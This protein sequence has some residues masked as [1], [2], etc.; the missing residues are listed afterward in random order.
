MTDTIRFQLRLTGDTAE[1][2]QFQG[3]DGYMALAGFAWMLSLATNYV[4]TGKI[5]Q[6]GEFDGREAVRATAP[7]EGSVVVDFLV[8]LQ[9]N[10]EVIFGA[11]AAGASAP[12]LLS[13]ILSRVINRNLGQEDPDA[14]KLIAELIRR[15]GGDVEALVAISEAPLRQAH[16]LIGNGATRITLTGG[17]N[18]RN[19]FD[20]NSKDYVNLS[21]KDDTLLSKLVSVSAFNANSGYGSVFD[22]DLGHVVPFS[23]SRETLRR[24]KKVFSWGL[25]Q[26]VQGTGKKIRISYTRVL[27]MDKRPKRYVINSAIKGE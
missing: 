18:V 16:R 24:F 6:R 12:I 9:N 3:Y 23:M 1:A 2:H 15:R 25:D 19:T 22:G 20:G 14:D 17:Y 7:S 21:Y 11:L 26:Y 27:A 4:D 8:Y 10:P 5:R 13:S